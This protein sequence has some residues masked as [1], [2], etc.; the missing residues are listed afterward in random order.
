MGK[1]IVTNKVMRM[2]DHDAIEYYENDKEFGLNFKKP[3][4]PQVLIDAIKK[5]L[6]KS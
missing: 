6:K 5:N 4:D 2:V 1:C 3:M